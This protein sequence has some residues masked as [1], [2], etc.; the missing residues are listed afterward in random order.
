MKKI[1]GYRIVKIPYEGFKPQWLGRFF[2]NSFS[3]EDICDTYSTVI[4]PSLEDA[5]EFLE[6]FI[7]DRWKK[8]HEKKEG[9]SVVYLTRGDDYWAE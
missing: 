8:L 4:F 3:R 7:R 2:W 5:K 1:Y 6:R 9:K